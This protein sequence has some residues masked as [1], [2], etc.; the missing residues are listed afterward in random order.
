MAKRSGQNKSK[1]TPFKRKNKKRKE[2]K[3]AKETN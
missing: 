2:K 3:E 1:I